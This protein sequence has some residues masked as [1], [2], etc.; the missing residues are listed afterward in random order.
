[1]SIPNSA[2]VPDGYMRNATGHLVPIDQVSEQDFLRDQVV[3]DLA[4]R[5]IGLHHELATFKQR[6]LRDIADLIQVAADKYEVQIGGK[7]GNVTLRSYDGQFRIDRAVQDR[8]AFTEQLEAAKELINQCID[9]WSEGA[10]PHI[11]ALVD[12]AFRTDGGGNVKTAAVL[13]LLRLDIQ[14]D[15]WQ[16]AMD[17]IRDSIQTLG[18]AVYVRVY[19]RIGES[20]QYRAIPLDLAAV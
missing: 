20:D 13:E 3:R 10:N 17:A 18:S 5:A 4:D 16:R 1:M 8:I 11:R 2:P 14:D 15:E 7:K 19:E 9:R 6:A 12:R